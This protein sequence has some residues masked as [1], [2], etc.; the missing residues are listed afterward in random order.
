M[1]LKE[2]TDSFGTI[3]AEDYK[4]TAVYLDEALHLIVKLEER[5]EALEAERTESKRLTSALYLRFAEL[6]SET[7]GMVQQ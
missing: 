3:S 1:N 7:F 4:L 6:E 2:L 5:I